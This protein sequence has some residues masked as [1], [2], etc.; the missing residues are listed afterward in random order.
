MDTAPIPVPSD[1]TVPVKLPRWVQRDDPGDPDSAAFRSGAAL[2][3]LDVALRAP[4]LPAPLL[5]DRLALRTAEACLRRAGRPER[6]PELRDEV[7]L[8]REGESP[9]PGGA[10]FLDW[11]R[12]TRLRL[13]PGWE[14]RARQVL[15]D[16]PAPADLPLAPV[17][18]AAALLAACLEAAPRA[19]VPGLILAEATLSAALGWTHPLPLLAGHLNRADLREPAQLLPACQRAVIAAAN[20]ALPL[21]EELTRRAARLAQVAPKLR[22]K[23][24]DAVVAL[25]LAEDAVSPARALTPV[26]R[27]SRHPMTDRAARR[28]CDRLVSLGAVRELSGRD[29][30]RIYGL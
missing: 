26:I 5:R 25:F 19:Q 16:L 20:E 29:T 21:A 14:A 7:H 10:V 3:A 17:A 27:G 13:G 18:R 11:R 15:P 8:L 6:L 23:A 22:A 12:A 4:G 2:M 9:G 30:F 28:I 1:D 24:S